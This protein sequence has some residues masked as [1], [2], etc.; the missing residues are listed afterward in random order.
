MFGFIV[1]LSEIWRLRIL[2]GNSYPNGFS[3]FKPVNYK[4]KKKMKDKKKL[5]TV[6]FSSSMNNTG[7]SLPVRFKK[8]AKQSI[9]KKDREE[10]IWYP[11]KRASTDPSQ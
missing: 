4:Q 8:N 11:N 9:R 5:K 7:N 1:S 10:T 6:K 2:Y 3:R